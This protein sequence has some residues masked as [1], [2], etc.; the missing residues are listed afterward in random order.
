M[1]TPP[2]PTTTQDRPGSEARA[3]RRPSEPTP[4]AQV[5]PP[6]GSDRAARAADADLLVDIPQLS[7][8]ELALEVESSLVLNRVKLDAKGL[9][10]GLFLKADLEHVVQL[11]QERSERHEGG[12]LRRQRGADVDRVRS[13]LRELLGAA[14]DAEPAPA[15]AEEARQ[16]RPRARDEDGA[17]QA[18]RDRQNGNGTRPHTGRHAAAQG[19][20]AAGLTAAGLAGG[21]L[22]EARVKPSRKLHIPRRRS[23]AQVLRDELAKRLP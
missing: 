11:A 8:D 20:V 23:R 1:S 15:A 21:A 5:L 14:R 13:G 3:E 17:E 7:V 10:V 18:G 12:W 9:Q 2:V 4:P 6:S 22:L 19:A 16:E